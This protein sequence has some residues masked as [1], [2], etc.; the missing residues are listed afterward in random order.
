MI[1]ETL[2]RLVR[3]L[4]KLPSIGEKTALRMAFHII[5]LPRSEA[6]S[7]AQCIL[8][9]KDKVALCSV[10]FNL[11]DCNPCSICRKYRG[12]KIASRHID[13]DLHVRAS[14]VFSPCRSL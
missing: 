12:A 6:Q 7:L 3:E 13:Q 4:T 8:E 11:T 5:A 10:C 14:L 2:N 9:V 1:A